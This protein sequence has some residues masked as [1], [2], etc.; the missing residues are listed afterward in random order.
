MSQRVGANL[1]ISQYWMSNIQGIQRKVKREP[2]RTTAAEILPIACRPL[3]ISTSALGT[4]ASRSALMIRA[5]RSCPSPMSAVRIRTRGSRSSKRAAPASS[6]PAACSLPF[7][8]GCLPGTGSGGRVV[9]RTHSTYLRTPSLKLVAAFQPSSESARSLE[10]A[11]PGKS[12]GRGGVWT[13]SQLSVFS[14]T[15]SAISRIV[16]TSSPERL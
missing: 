15:R 1:V 2:S 8:E 11:L 7:S 10:I 3:A 6:A 14:C 4:S 9:L 13:I 16:T 5:G 12:P